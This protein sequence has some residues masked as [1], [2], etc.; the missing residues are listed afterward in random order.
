MA[1]LAESTPPLPRAVPAPLCQAPR[2]PPCPRQGWHHG[3][4][5][6]SRASHAAGMAILP[7][8]NMKLVGAGLDQR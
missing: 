3:G 7:R 8:V 4:G 6:V 5:V 2:G 1:V